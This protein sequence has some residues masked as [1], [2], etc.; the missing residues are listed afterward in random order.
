MGEYY[1]NAIFGVLIAVT[2][3]ITV[4]GLRRRVVW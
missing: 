1:Y 3:K 4:F 2:A